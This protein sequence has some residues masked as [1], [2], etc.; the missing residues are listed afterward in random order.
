M[1][2]FLNFGSVIAS[3]HYRSL[4]LLLERPK[5]HEEMI[6]LG[7]RRRRRC[8][9]LN[10]AQIQRSDTL[11]FYSQGTHRGATHSTPATSPAICMTFADD[12]TAIH[13]GH[14]TSTNYPTQLSLQLTCILTH[15]TNRLT[16]DTILTD[17]LKH[18]HTQSTGTCSSRD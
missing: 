10:S 9:S 8:I 13:D 2:G 1:S 18:T 15:V 5:E 6:L 17:E 4:L 14:A 11:V 12:T 7:V 3:I 16:R